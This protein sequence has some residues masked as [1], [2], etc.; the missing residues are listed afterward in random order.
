MA[1]AKKEKTKTK[2]K[3]KGAAKAKTKV[4]AKARGKSAAKPNA[5]AKAKPAKAKP[6]KAS[7]AKAKPAKAKSVEAHPEIETADLLFMDGANVPSREERTAALEQSKT[8]PRYEEVRKLVL[9]MFRDCYP[10]TPPETDAKILATDPN[11]Y[12]L[13]PSPFYEYLEEKFAVEQDANNEYFGGYGGKIEST[14]AF[15]A[16]RWDGKLHRSSEEMSGED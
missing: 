5:K 15:L 11:E 2:V 10:S 14:I 8:Q 6:A 13:D 1:K 4:K 3:V 12:D 16:S 7:K 9:E